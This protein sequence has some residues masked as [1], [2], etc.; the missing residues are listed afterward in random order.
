[1]MSLSLDCHADSEQKSFRAI[2][3]LIKITRLISYLTSFILLNF[4]FPI[5]FRPARFIKIVC[6]QFKIPFL[7][8]RY[9]FFFIFKRI[10]PKAGIFSLIKINFLVKQKKNARINIYYN[11]VNN[12][13]LLLLFSF[14]IVFD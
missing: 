9:I 14:L 11:F 7:F 13:L 3:I 4:L 10:S 12:F 8:A 5:A 1:M 2:V 6:I